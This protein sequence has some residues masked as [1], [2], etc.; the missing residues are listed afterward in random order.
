MTYKQ[1]EATREVRLW[2]TQI[3]V[4]IVTVAI[5]SGIAIPEVRQ[6]VTTQCSKIGKAISNKLK[7]KEKKEKEKVNNQDDYS[8]FHV[9]FNKNTNEY[10]MKRL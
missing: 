9:E 8:V 10:R 4:P 3:A 7:K 6:A 2:I 1:I 5:A